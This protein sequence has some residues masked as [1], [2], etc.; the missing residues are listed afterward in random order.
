MLR[1]CG[2][3]TVLLLARAAALATDDHANYCTAAT[4]VPTDGTPFS[5][6]ID[7]AA[8][9]DWLT[10][11]GLQ[12]HAYDFSTIDVSPGFAA[13]VAVTEP[14]C[15]SQVF[16]WEGG[17]PAATQH[18]VAPATQSYTI[19]VGALPPP[20]TGVVFLA[21]ADLG[22]VPD[23]H[24]NDPLLATPISANGAIVTASL[25]YVGDDD[26]LSFSTL[27]RHVYRIEYRPTPSVPDWGYAQI[28]LFRDPN[29]VW[30]ANE[31]L[32]TT[33]WPIDFSGF[34]YYVT[35]G[36]TGTYYLR[37]GN[38]S[39]LTPQPYEL[40]V[41]DTLDGTGDAHANAC[42]AATPVTT[43]GATFDAVIDPQSDRDWFR[44]DGVAGHR[45]T[46][47][48]YDVSRN[49]SARVQVYESDC[50]A[51]IWERLGGTPWSIQTL[52]TPSTQS[53]TLRVSGNSRVFARLGL[54]DEGPVPDDHANSRGAATPILTD[55]QTHAGVVQ[56]LGDLD[57]FAFAV[58]AQRA[59]V[60]EFRS[61]PG[62]LPNDVIEAEVFRGSETTSRG[63]LFQTT[64]PD[65]TPFERLLCYVP[66]GQAGSHYI[67]VSSYNNPGPLPYELRVSEVILPLSDE[68]A[69]T[70][71][72][73]TP[74]AADG[75]EFTAVID[76]ATDVDW[77]TFEAVAG[78][79]Y[80]FTTT[81]ISLDLRAQVDVYASD[82]ALPIL[83][84][85][86][87][88]TSYPPAFTVPFS[89][90]YTLR[91]RNGELPRVGCI[92]LA[93]SDQG[94]VDDDHANLRS[95][96]TPASPV[97]QP[98]DGVLQYDGDLDWFWFDLQAEGAYAIEYRS[99]PGGV[100]PGGAFN[101]QLFRESEADDRAQWSFFGSNWPRP[102]SQF[103]YSIAAS[104]VGRFHLVFWSASAVPPMPYQMRVLP[105]AGPSGDFDADG[106]PDLIDN[107]PTAPNPLQEDADVDG[108]GDCCAP[109]FPDSDADG[110]ND[111]C[112]N[113]PDTPNAN[114]ADADGDGIGD[115]CQSPAPCPGDVDCDGDVDL[116]DIDPFVARIGCPLGGACATNCPWQSADLDGDGDVDFFDIDPF[117]ARLGAACP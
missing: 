115:V 64:T 21:L 41:I 78:R 38:A 83:E 70:C 112:D 48:T 22:P 58:V 52:V 17:T 57:W 2:T 23:D 13:T 36:S 18:F 86:P 68:H 107:C 66:A 79:R 29:A 40:R 42:D 9:F 24:A 82:C 87:S 7:P 25:D 3:I 56:Y 80:E 109:S 74:I 6:V 28:R 101:V 51:L 85:Q 88:A 27:A 49:T 104:E 102:F 96:G 50:N 43:D 76:P 95:L 1:F 90:T 99:M 61:A 73:A 92:T 35:A 67:N 47:S 10:F 54:T 55:G 39:G 113:C 5:A 59:Y 15:A 34:Y 106:V 81:L 53:Y 62:G 103:F 114:Q 20:T 12:G 77:F 94:P 69:D 110:V 46:F 116:F 4:P 108:Y 26:W 105:A 32:E 31:L 71:D 33:Y 111:A 91:A 30:L 8:D 75:A 84:W 19:R 72:A 97:G 45:Y 65:G 63:Q 60:V 93:L 37:L 11:E 44:F 100:P 117:V 89:G 14:D 98:L 16:Y